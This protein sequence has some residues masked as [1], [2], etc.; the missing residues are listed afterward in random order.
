ML[1]TVAVA[2]GSVLLLAAPALASDVSRDIREV[3]KDRAEINQERREIAS[4]EARE[5]NALRNGNV[6]AYFR[7]KA[8]EAR[9]RR[10]LGR[11]EAKLRHD[12]HELHEDFEHRRY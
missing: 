4:D 8:D 10:E 12:R 6:G 7:A 11:E 5:R 1:K 2:I 3:R 9:D